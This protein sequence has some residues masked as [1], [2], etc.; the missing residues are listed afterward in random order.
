MQEHYNK[1]REPVGSCVM[2][3]KSDLIVEFDAKV[4][5]LGTVKLTPGTLYQKF[6]LCQ[7]KS[8]GH[9]TGAY[10]L[11]SQYR[12]NEPVYSDRYGSE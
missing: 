1:I 11:H 10:Y 6:Y 5:F 3:G 7:D 4:P 2:M 12:N 8:G 9:F